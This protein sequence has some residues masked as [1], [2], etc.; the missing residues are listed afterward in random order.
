MSLP[1]A[2]PARRLVIPLALT[3]SSLLGC[4]SSTT[5][6]NMWRDPQYSRPMHGVLVIGMLRN[7]AARRN[8]E[9]QMV[10]ELSARGVNAS[11][12]YQMF[13]GELPDTDAVITGVRRQG[14]DGVMLIHPLGF[15]SQSHYVPGYVRTV[16]SLGYNPWYGVYYNYYRH[17]YEPGYVE[18]E[19]VVRHQI[20][21]YST[22]SSGR[23]VWTGTSE[24]VDPASREQ[25]RQKV[26]TKVVAELASAG[27]IGKG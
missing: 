11:P 27:V 20:D 15:Q 3:L 12:S 23:L 21:V 18:T 19:Q 26:A 4:A 17:I 14:F 1:L 24:S 16:P 6:T 2:A 22:G 9:D 10:G 5:L 25:V 13:P 7:P 8:W